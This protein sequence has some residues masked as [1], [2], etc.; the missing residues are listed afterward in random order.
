VVVFSFTFVVSGNDR[1]LIG[2]VQAKTGIFVLQKPGLLNE[3]SSEARL[4]FEK[5]RSACEDT[6]EELLRS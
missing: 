3:E 6:G 2:E 1:G 5:A 4:H